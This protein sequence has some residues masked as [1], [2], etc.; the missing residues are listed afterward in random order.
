MSNKWHGGKGDRRRKQADDK[1]YRSGW[2]RIF[3]NDGESV[4]DCS[5][6]KEKEK[7]K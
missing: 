1:K 6:G 4:N 2:D 7:T 3:G 5:N